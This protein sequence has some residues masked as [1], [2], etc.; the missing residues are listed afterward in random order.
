VTNGT[1]I[2]PEEFRLLM[3]QIF[4]SRDIEARHRAADELMCTTLRS[5]GYALGVEIFEKAMKWYA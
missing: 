5:W 4:L 3:E 2:D 1:P